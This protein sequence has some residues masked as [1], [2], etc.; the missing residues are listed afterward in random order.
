MSRTSTTILSVLL[1]LAAFFLAAGIEFGYFLLKPVAPNEP[2]SVMVTEGM[3]FA[4]VAARLK[5]N[6]VIASAFD[7]K[8][9]A[10]M[11]GQS[12][13]IQAGDY[14]FGEPAVPGRI[15]DRMVAGDV[16]RYKF[17]IPEG[18]TVREIAARLDAENLVE[19]KK[20]QQLA[21]DRDFIRS[22][23]IEASSL[24]GY[25]FPETYMV[26]KGMAPERLLRAMVDQFE[27]HLSPE[28]VADAQKSDLSPDQMVTLASIIQKEAGNVAEMPLI[29][30]V[31]HNRLRKGMPLQADPT[32]IYGL[33]DFDGNLTRKDLATPTPYNTY[34][35]SGL[36]PGPIA[37]PGIEALQAAANPADVDYLFFVSR[38]DG[39]HV[40]SR[41]LREHNRAV[42]RYQIH[43]RTPASS[44]PSGAG[45]EGTKGHGAPEPNGRG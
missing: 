5:E 21:G 27:K 20:F 28:L 35:R 25:L 17:T 41:T 3:P 26:V 45:N 37:S 31:F 14:D 12:R 32:V 6:G 23:G 18:L 13:Q 16:R 33:K 2:C 42:Q 22:L 29:S 10:R 19:G 34:R 39:T 43:R 1:A 7:F 9:L 40:F 30:A 4:E 8:V 44:E 38:G 11:R 15:L 24:E 36:P